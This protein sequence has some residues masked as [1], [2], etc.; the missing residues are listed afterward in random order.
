M[1]PTQSRAGGLWGGVEDQLKME[2][3]QR[4]LILVKP[5]ESVELQSVQGNLLC[6]ES[7]GLTI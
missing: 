6:E 1:S 7:I 5:T 3:E 4:R 2:T